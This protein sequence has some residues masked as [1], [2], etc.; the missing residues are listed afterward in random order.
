MSEM[1][2]AAFETAS[3]ARAALDRLRGDAFKEG[4]LSLLA[5][6]DLRETNRGLT[7]DGG[8]PA[9]IDAMLD[10]MT[11]A[12]DLKVDDY[13]VAGAG[14]LPNLLKPAPDA[15]L[16][17]LRKALVEAGVDATTAG[18]FED[19]VRERGL[20]VGVAAENAERGEKALEVLQN[21]GAEALARVDVS[22]QRRD[23][24]R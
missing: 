19:T 7:A 12:P 4:G 9:A 23:L 21:E 11:V 15:G 3:R 5:R 24:P 8:E 17:G 16:G 1:I 6:Q 10:A 2:F 18:V 22:E 20:M 13:E 14:A